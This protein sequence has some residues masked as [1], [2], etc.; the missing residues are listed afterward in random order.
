[1]KSVETEMNKY[2]STHQLFL[3]DKTTLEEKQIELKELNLKSVVLFSLIIAIKKTA[4]F[5]TG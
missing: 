1:M 2:K 5:I 3:K 4:D